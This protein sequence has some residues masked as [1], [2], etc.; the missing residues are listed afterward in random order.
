MNDA[1]GSFQRN[2]RVLSCDPCLR[3]NSSTENVNVSDS[4]AMGADPLHAV[5]SLGLPPKERL[6]IILRDVEGLPT[7]EVATALGNTVATV[8]VQLSRARV[9]LREF[10]QRK[11]Q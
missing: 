4:A 7:E 11:L 9:K 6:A 8:R 2:L 10:V 1:S 5:V 3:T